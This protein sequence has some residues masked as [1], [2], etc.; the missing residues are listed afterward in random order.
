[1]LCI[2]LSGFY[3]IIPKKFCNDKLVVSVPKLDHNPHES[4]YFAQI[5]AFDGSAL[6]ILFFLV[7]C[8]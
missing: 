7:I 8:N 3:L 1:M 6:C 4:H 5:L 2:V